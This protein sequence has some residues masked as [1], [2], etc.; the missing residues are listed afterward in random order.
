M[1][2]A[3]YGSWG[4]SSNDYSVFSPKS[5]VPV[6]IRFVFEAKNN[7]TRFAFATSFLV[8]KGGGEYPRYSA[9]ISGMVLDE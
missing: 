8:N 1:S 2:G 9:G 3:T 5:P 6:V 4:T 7:G